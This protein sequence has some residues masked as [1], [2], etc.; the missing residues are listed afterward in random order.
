MADKKLP[1]EW[2]WWDDLLR[3]KKLQ[4]LQDGC[5]HPGYYRK[6]SGGKNQNARWVPVGIWPSFDKKTTIVEI[7]GRPSSKTPFDAIFSK[8][9]QGVSYEV[10]MD[11]TRN[12]APWPDA[13]PVAPTPPD[14]ELQDAEWKEVPAE[15]KGTNP[16]PQPPNIPAADREVTRHDNDP[17]QDHRL[18]VEHQLQLADEHVL[19]R[20][21]L[22]KAIGTQ[23]E[24]NSASEH[25]NRIATLGKWFE[26]EYEVR[27]RP[28]LEM[29]KMLRVD[30]LHRAN[31]AKELAHTLT[32]HMADFLISEQRKLEAAQRAAAEA[33]AARLR[34]LEAKGEPPPPPPPPG[35]PEAPQRAAAGG[36][37]GRKTTVREEPIAIVDDYMA[38]ATKLIRGGMAD[39]PPNYCGDA[40]LKS[41]LDKLAQRHAK[42]MPVG[43]V[44]SGI[45]IEK[46]AKARR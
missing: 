32:Q 33:E 1:P 14:L 36:L 27:N 22:E 17:P 26:S 45:R 25:A 6:P 42:T 21:R 31:E 20:K 34:E 16:A 2:A 7:D 12:N 10:Y 43:P 24:A 11:V 9:L 46:Q 5:V 38:W 18:L 15:R 35:A 29:Q 8:N 40:D 19:V 37:T 39:A 44:V 41:L 13:P 28:L 3:T 4:P 23:D 30:Y